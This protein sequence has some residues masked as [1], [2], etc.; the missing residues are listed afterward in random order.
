MASTQER[1]ADCCFRR[2]KLT[3]SC[4][5]TV[6]RTL[7]T[8]KL[9][10]L[11]LCWGWSN[12]LFCVLLFPLC[13]AR[14]DWSAFSL[15]SSKRGAFEKHRA[16]AIQFEMFYQHGLKKRGN[17]YII[18]VCMN[19]AV[20]KVNTV[21]DCLYTH[22]GM[23]VFVVK[24][25]CGG[26]GEWKEKTSVHLF[27]DNSLSYFGTCRQTNTERLLHYLMKTGSL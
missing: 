18:F 26:K 4:D 9:K 3:D 27:I 6:N 1:G 15:F 8:G 16:G 13:E 2:A 17:T 5:R 23:F 14:W 12:L 7:G 10:Y 25:C 19:Y 24:L 20:L 21:L 11:L 22:S